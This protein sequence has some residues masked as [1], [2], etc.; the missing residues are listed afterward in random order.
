MPAEFPTSLHRTSRPL[1]GASTLVFAIGFNVPYAILAVTFDYPGVLRRPAGEVLDLFAAGGTSLVLTWYAFLW[2]ALL[3]VPLAASLALS[4]ERVAAPTGLA[5]G[6]AIAGGLSGVL[7]A[8]GLAR[9]V[10]VIPVQAAAHAS[11]DVSAAVVFDTLNQYG[12][13]AIGEHLGQLL[14]ALF[15]CQLASLQWAEH[16]RMLGLAGF[17]SAFG[18]A[19]GTGEGLALSLGAA[20]DAFSLFTIGGFLTFS[21][22]LVAT[23]LSLIWP[24]RT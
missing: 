13:V 1:L 10:F 15:A 17:A 23:A 21:A 20:G 2:A 14:L 12:G 22:W 3:F 9:W 7:Q 11:G 19:I 18:I 16:R 6:A 8:I 4:R 24:A 5:I